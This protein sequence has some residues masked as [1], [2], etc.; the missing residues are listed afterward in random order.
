MSDDPTTGPP[1]PA[2]DAHIDA[3]AEFFATH[4]ACVAASRYVRV[5]TT[6][7]VFFS[8]RPGESWHLLREREGSRLQPGRAKDPDFAFCFPPR[9]I[10]HIT[11]AADDVGGLAVALFT[12][13]SEE[14]VS[15]R[16][17]F[18]VIASWTRLARGGYVRLL[19]AGGPQAL[20]VTS[21]M[22][23]SSPL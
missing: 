7:K 19:L 23:A 5:G 8:H 4:P 21:R 18:R 14:D 17:R 6:S 20:G 9:A 22:F 2:A 11:T 15:L 13:I 12:L 1:A 16:V 10:D 3:L